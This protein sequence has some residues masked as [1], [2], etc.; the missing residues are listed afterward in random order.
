MK[1][2]PVE[3]IDTPSIDQMEVESVLEAKSE[4]ES[5]M[6][7][8]KDYLFYGTLLE[9]GSERWNIIRMAFR[10]IM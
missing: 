3:Q 7:P 8:I 1:L 5:W 6:T 2:V 9:R 4:K 10:Y